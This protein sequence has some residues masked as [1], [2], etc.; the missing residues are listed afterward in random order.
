MIKGIAIL[1]NRNYFSFRQLH[2]CFVWILAPHLCSLVCFC[3]EMIWKHRCLADYLENEEGL[4]LHNDLSSNLHVFSFFL[5]K[6]KTKKNLSMND[7]DIWSFLQFF[8]ILYYT[9]SLGWFFGKW[10]LNAKLQLPCFRN[11]VFKTQDT[12]YDSR[13]CKSKASKSFLLLLV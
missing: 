10:Q 9:Q 5:V 13:W 11:F 7:S 6:D 1:W 3:I 2:L 4:L 8:S 12:H